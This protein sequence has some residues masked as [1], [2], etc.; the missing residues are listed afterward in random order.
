M[1]ELF[2][3]KKNIDFSKLKLTEEGKYSITKKQDSQQILK[4][5]CDIIDPLKPSELELTDLTGNVGGD[6]ILFGM[7]FLHVNSIELDKQNFDALKHNVEAFDLKNVKLYNGDSTELYNWKTDVLYLDPPWGGPSY[8]E[9]E[10]LDLYL[11]DERIDLFLES[12]LDEPWRPKYIFL[13]LPRNYNFERFNSLPNISSITK[14][15]IRGFCLIG[16]TTV[17]A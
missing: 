4:H 11:G 15:R 13:K 6:T 3:D 17:N 8:K 2:P 16:M 14:F 12:V 9:K 1:N 10:N 7:H 5:I